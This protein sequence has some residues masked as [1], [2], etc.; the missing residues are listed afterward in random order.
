MAYLFLGIFSICER[1]SEFLDIS[2]GKEALSVVAQ[3]IEN[4][5]LLVLTFRIIVSVNGRYYGLDKKWPIYL[6]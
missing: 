2:T 1:V 5:A 4:A 3:A 6:E